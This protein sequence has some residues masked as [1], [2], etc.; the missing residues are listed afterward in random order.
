MKPSDDLPGLMSLTSRSQTVEGPAKDVAP[1]PCKLTI[2]REDLPA[3]ATALAEVDDF[4]A[5]FAIE[6]E[7]GTYRGPLPKIENPQDSVMG[8]QGLWAAL[9]DSGPSTAGMV[10]PNVPAHQVG[11]SST[12][13]GSRGGFTSSDG[14]NA[15]V[16]IK[17]EVIVP[18]ETEKPIPRGTDETNPVMERLFRNRPNPYVR[19]L[20]KRSTVADLLQLEAKE[21][22]KETLRKRNVATGSAA[23]DMQVEVKQEAQEEGTSEYLKEAARGVS[24]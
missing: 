11:T 20:M 18:Y 4:L 12:Q 7:T 5:K 3:D 22:L 24:E 1:I 6:L 9:P 23:N 15:S 2:K 21:S 13:Q 10:E 16:F 8:M 14:Q 17:N 19:A